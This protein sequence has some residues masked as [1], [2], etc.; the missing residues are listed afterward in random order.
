MKTSNI[1]NIQN[2][3][4]LFFTAL[5]FSSMFFISCKDDDEDNVG[6]PY[7]NIEGNPTGL[8]LDIKGSTTSYVVRSNRPWQIVAQSEGDWLQAFPAEGEDDGI[9]KII[10]KE[11]PTFDLRTMN[12]VFVVDG[13]EE[14][15]MFLVEQEANV[16]F[17]SILEA[18]EG[19]S[20]ASAEGDVVVNIKA[21]VDWTYSLDNESWL[22]EK[23]LT[24]SQ[25]TLTAANNDGP[26][27][28]VILTV[29]SP[30]SP[31]LSAKVKLT[32]SAGSVVFEEDFSWLVYGN[33]IPYET[34]GEKR[35]DTWTQEEKDRGWE[36]TPNPGS[37]GQQLVYARTGFLK[38]GK[39]SYGSDII[40][41]KLNIQ[42]TKKLKVTFKAAAYISSGGSVDDR[43]LK[44]SVL[45]AGTPSVSEFTIDNIPNSK[46]QDEA[47]IANNIWDP[48]RAYSYTIT[49]ATSDTQI[50]FLGGD[51]DL[52][53]VGQGKNRIFLDDIKVEIIQD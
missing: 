14:P 29:T 17:V 42:G 43:I 3:L 8:S 9:F 38:L 48:E 46:A 36:V 21:N 35:Y 25:I 47:G 16:P 6:S 4:V 26:Q 2:T 13:K 15:V 11:N 44:I 49:G 18:A 32:Q 45:G 22:T 12:F 34:T 50:R 5:F 31:G 24:D 33:I 53:G 1:F 10:V 28:S 40:S 7:F 51:L 37:S 23:A 41:P 52:N 20:V 30:A 27:R 39:T 19:I